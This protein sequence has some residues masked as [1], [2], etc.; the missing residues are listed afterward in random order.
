VFCILMC[1][2]MHIN[3]QRVT[4]KLDN[5]Y[6]TLLIIHRVKK[7]GCFGG[8]VVFCLYMTMDSNT[9]VRQ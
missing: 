9:N 7:G 6:D 8:Y 5:F 2:L 1:I 4:L 3:M